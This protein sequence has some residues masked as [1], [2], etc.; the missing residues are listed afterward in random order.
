MGNFAFVGM[1]IAST[2]IRIFKIFKFQVSQ[3][4]GLLEAVEKKMED[5]TEFVRWWDE[6]VRPANRP[7][8]VSGQ[9][10]L[11]VEQAGERSQP[12]LGT[13]RGRRARP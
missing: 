5:Q 2:Q 11:S 7:K 10:Q 3:N 4:P 8:T 6:N 13:G 1:N 9:K 12:T